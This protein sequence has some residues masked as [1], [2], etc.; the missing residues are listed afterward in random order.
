MDGMIEVAGDSA[1]KDT[2]F[3]PSR[4]AATEKA[5]ALVEEVRSQLLNYEARF[6]PRKRLRRLPD[7]QRFDRIVSAIVCDLAHCA[8]T[9]PG[10]WRHI[11]LSKRES[12]QDAA[13]AS[14]MTE[15]RIDIIRWMAEPEMDWLELRK[16]AQVR[17]PFGGQQSTIRASARLRRYMEDWE[18]G[19]EDLGR[20]PELLGDPVILR[21]PKL[22]GQAK[23]LPVPEG[24]PAATYRS[25]LLRLNDWL[26]R[27]DIV[28]DGH[29]EHGRPRDTGDR[30]LKRIFN[31]G[32][33]DEGGRLYGGFWQS[34]SKDAR[35]EDLLIGEEP[36]VSLDF[37]QCAINIAYAQQGAR[38][39]AGDLYVIPGL[40]GH[41]EGVKA[42][43][44]ALLHSPKALGRFPR[45]TRQ[46]F[47]KRFK[48]EDV[49]ERVLS[50]HS[51][52]RPLLHSGFG[53]RGFFIES[54]I[55]MRCLLDLMERGIVALP[56]H[57]CL[58]VPLPA[59]CIAREMMQ[60][61]FRETTG[62]LRDVEVDG[63]CAFLPRG[64]ELPGSVS[65]TWIRSPEDQGLGGYLSDER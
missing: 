21:G 63:T 58:V 11:S 28:C 61:S 41:R 25:E 46:W 52:I 53:M 40:E 9:A 8:L 2:R 32:R 38:P 5:R 62:A 20:D 26:A 35:L 3:S 31:N 14:F 4:W 51:A 56:I 12:A 15:A 18:I 45:G 60:A 22:K 29:D 16:A 17:N 55:L 43:L 36:V 37:G 64:S 6:H 34:M 47:P 50:H 39:P 27:A 19:L 13:G 57:D 30:W 65:T 7:Q 59:A 23:T 33:L 1:P 44:N 48:V 54:Q 10:A 24:E 49:V 42:L